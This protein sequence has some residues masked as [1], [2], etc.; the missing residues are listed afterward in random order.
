MSFLTSYQKN[1]LDKLIKPVMDTGK[2]KLGWLK[3]ATGQFSPRAKGGARDSPIKG[4]LLL[5][6]LV[7][8]YKTKNRKV[9]KGD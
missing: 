7:I 3:E 9:R 1:K 2:I 5:F 4:I 6:Y 8:N